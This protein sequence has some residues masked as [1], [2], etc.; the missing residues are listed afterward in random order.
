MGRKIPARRHHGVRDPL[1]QAA[2]RLALYVR[3]F[4]FGFF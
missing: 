1:V 3:W 2:Q 4:E